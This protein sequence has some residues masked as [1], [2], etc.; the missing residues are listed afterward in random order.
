MFLKLSAGF[1]T[2]YIALPDATPVDSGGEYVPAR[3]HR[4]RTWK[5]TD[6]TWAKPASALHPNALRHV[7]AVPVTNELRPAIV[8]GAALLAAPPLTPTRPHRS[9]TAPRISATQ[10]PR[11][12]ASQHLAARQP[13]LAAASQLSGLDLAR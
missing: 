7:N 13:R 10:H 12:S 11:R 6:D 2:L 3:H 5:R 4:E 8:T 9:S 1:D